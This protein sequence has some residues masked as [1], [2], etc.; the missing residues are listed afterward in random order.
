MLV[1][2]KIRK[3]I[4]DPD[5]N[6]SKSESVLYFDIFLAEHIEFKHLKMMLKKNQMI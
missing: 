4:A 1:Y 3:R 2:G 5:G 6:R